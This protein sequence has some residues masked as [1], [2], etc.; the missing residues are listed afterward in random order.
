MR[1]LILL[2]LV[3]VSHGAC[4]AI[5]A[6]EWHHI[7]IHGHP[8]YYAIL[9]HGSP[10]LLLHG[11]GESGEQSFARQIAAFA[12]HHLVGLGVQ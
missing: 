8:I 9:G 11:G 1:L 12:R 10:R 4:A 6:K 7:T 3:A 5:S 2:S